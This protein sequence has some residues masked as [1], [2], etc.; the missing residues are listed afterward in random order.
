MLGWA[1]DR[2]WEQRLTTQAGQRVL[3][4]GL[5]ASW[6]RGA[7]RLGGGGR[8]QC[9]HPAV[10]PSQGLCLARRYSWPDHH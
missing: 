2:K 9:K 10:E 7:R 6:Q 1:P 4:L 8:G 5:K 3:S